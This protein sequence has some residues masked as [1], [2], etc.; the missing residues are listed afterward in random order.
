MRG[1]GGIVSFEVAGTSGRPPGRECLSHPLIAPSL[2]GAE[3]LIGQPADEFPPTYD[4]GTPPVGIKGN[5]IRYSVGIEADLAAL[6]H[7]SSR[8][9]RSAPS[10]LVCF[11]FENLCS[12]QPQQ[13]PNR[14]IVGSVEG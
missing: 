2:G 10:R 9:A 4:R 8:R 13:S 1:F 11:D 14:R 5:L 7:A 12:C 6:E 3:S